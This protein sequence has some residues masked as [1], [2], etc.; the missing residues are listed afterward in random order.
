MQNLPVEPV[1]FLFFRN[2]GSLI[3]VCVCVRVC[4]CVC[5]GEGGICLNVLTL[6]WL[7]FGKSSLLQLAPSVWLLDLSVATA[8]VSIYV[9]RVRQLNVRMFE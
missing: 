2:K 9:H 5:V 8:P 1:V 4:V 6:T 3:E 7:C